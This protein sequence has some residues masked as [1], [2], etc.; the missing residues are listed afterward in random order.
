MNCE[1]QI[2]LSVTWNKKTIPCFYSLLFSRD[3]Q[4]HWEKS[5]IDED[6]KISSDSGPDRPEISAA[7]RQV[8]LWERGL[9]RGFFVE[10]EKLLTS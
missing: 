5:I 2:L 7:S 3:K 9:T 10:K 6:V 1:Y 4:R 8:V